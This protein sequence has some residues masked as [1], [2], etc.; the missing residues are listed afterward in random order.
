[1]LLRYCLT[2]LSIN[3][4]QE[5]GKGKKRAREDDSEEESIKQAFNKRMTPVIEKLERQIIAGG[6][7]VAP[8][9]TQEELEEFTAK[10]SNPEDVAAYLEYWGGDDVDLDEGLDGN[11]DEDEDDDSDDL[12]VVV[13]EDEEEEE[14]SDDGEDLA[15]FI[16]DDDEL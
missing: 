12:L 6:A 5:K 9:I 7:D 13:S 16:N 10:A 15:D 8:G 4:K 14:D 11:G 1:M 3:I 2:L